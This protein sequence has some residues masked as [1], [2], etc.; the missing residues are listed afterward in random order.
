MALQSYT[1]SVSFPAFTL[2]HANFEG[3]RLNLSVSCG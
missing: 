2:W 1:F 3:H